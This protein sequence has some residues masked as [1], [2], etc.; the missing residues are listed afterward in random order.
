MEFRDTL[1]HA[2]E[3]FAQFAFDFLGR[4]Y[5]ERHRDLREDEF[6]PAFAESEDV[7]FHGAERLAERSGDFLV[8]LFGIGSEAEKRAERG[9]D[10]RFPLR[11]EFFTEGDERMIENGERPAALEEAVRRKIVHGLGGVAFLRPRGI[12]ARE[13][14][15]SALLRH[16]AVVFVAEEAPRAGE[17]EGAQLSSCGVRL[18]QR[19]LFQQP[20]KEALREILG[21]V[22]GAAR[23]PDVGIDGFGA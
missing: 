14:G 4:R 6:A 16:G 3:E 11:G 18:G 13:H 23:A 1:L 19:V 2:A 9:E 8:A 21:I 5:G 10:F 7:I 17:Q 12:E 22:C 15:R 20:R